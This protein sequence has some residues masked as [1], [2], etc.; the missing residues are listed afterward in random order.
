M[1]AEL[2]LVPGAV[3]C[4]ITLSLCVCVCMYTAVLYRSFKI[5][6]LWGITIFIIDEN[7]LF[8]DEDR[9]H[10]YLIIHWTIN[11]FH[12]YKVKQS[13]YRPGQSLGVP[14]TEATRFHDSSSLSSLVFSPKAGFGRNQS[15][16]RR[17]VWLWQKPIYGENIN[18][19]RL[20]V[21]TYRDV[22]YTAESS[23]TGK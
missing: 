5:I 17:P 23:V 14:G 18:Q 10:C 7:S 2:V 12:L 6:V 20:S 15:P 11:I 21:L 9:F 16:V 1:I 4:K 22:G 8:V 19:K 13:L 3:D